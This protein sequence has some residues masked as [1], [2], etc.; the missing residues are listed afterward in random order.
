MADVNVENRVAG[1]GAA[2]L[3]PSQVAVGEADVRVLDGAA[4]GPGDRGIAASAAGPVP[5]PGDASPEPMG[6]GGSS[7]EPLA[8]CSNPAEEAVMQEARGVIARARVLHGWTGRARA[9]GPEFRGEVLHRVVAD[10]LGQFRAVLAEGAPVF[11]Q[12]R[13]L[14]R[15]LDQEAQRVRHAI[16]ESETTVD[17]LRLRHLIGEL[18]REEYEARRE[19]LEQE[20][21]GHRVA[22]G[23]VAARGARLDE[24]LLAASQVQN[25]LDQ[26]LR[27]SADLVEGWDSGEEEVA[28][29]PSAPEAARGNAAGPGVR[30]AAESGDLEEDIPIEAASG[31]EDS[32]GEVPPV[33]AATLPEIAVSATRNAAEARPSAADDGESPPVHSSAEWQAALAR[34][35][36]QPST[37]EPGP[38]ARLH[39]TQADGFQ[40]TV[41]FDGDVISVGRGRNNDIQIRHDAKASRY[42]CRMVRRGAEFWIEDNRSR[43]GT[44]VDGVPAP[45]RR[46]LGG[47]RIGVGD[48]LI[49]FEIVA[50]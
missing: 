7:A 36:L 43:N 50:D 15:S 34:E 10:Y 13:R 31:E 45:R 30:G 47:E 14:R 42:H 9:L 23:G 4:P 6:A 19:S 46:L 3:P 38:R 17:E 12:V 25:D 18:G 37:S 1:N 32:F 48:T 41:R 27:E 2:S 5:E 8:S 20:V 35:T 44:L 21:E 16:D 33:G 24:V 29:P 40:E 49:R 22:L 11:G 39:V 28:P 26:L